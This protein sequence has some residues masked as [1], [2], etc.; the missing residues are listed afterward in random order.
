MP[1]ATP[2]G[3]ARRF[4]AVRVGYAASGHRRGYGALS[5]TGEAAVALLYTKLAIRIVGSP[6]VARGVERRGFRRGEM[7]VSRAK[8]GLEL[9]GRAGTQDGRGHPGP[10]GQPRQPDLGHRH[11]A[12]ARDLLHGLDD[13]PGALH[14]PAVIGFHAAVRVLAEAGGAGWALAPPGLC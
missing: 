10:V 6:R 9:S 11:T 1:Q 2:A 4:F 7:Q 14:A 3:T 13:V 5:A 8:V 12:F